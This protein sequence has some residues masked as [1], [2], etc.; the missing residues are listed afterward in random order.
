MRVDFLPMIYQQSLEQL[1]R[2]EA[3]SDSRVR[4]LRRTGFHAYANFVVSV[5]IPQEEAE[6]AAVWKA[7][8]SEAFPMRRREFNPEQNDARCRDQF[9]FFVKGKRITPS[10]LHPSVPHL[11]GK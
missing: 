2:Q 5:I 3:E 7:N 1:K 4:L 11:T 8:D 9:R 6:S 10:D